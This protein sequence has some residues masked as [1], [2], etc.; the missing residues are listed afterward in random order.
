V[1]ANFGADLNFSPVPEPLLAPPRNLSWN[2][3]WNSNDPA[4]GGSGTPPLETENGWRIP[5]EVVVVMQAVAAAGAA[6][7]SPTKRHPS[8]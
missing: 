3:L 2:L 1:L 5:G 7:D 6:G 4:Y 8:P